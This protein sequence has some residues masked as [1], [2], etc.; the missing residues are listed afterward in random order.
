MEQVVESEYLTETK[1]AILERRKAKG[2]TPEQVFVKHSLHAVADV[3]HKL[4][5]HAALVYLAILGTS[6]TVTDDERRE[7]F[8]VRNS[9][10]NATQLGDRQFRRAV[11]LLIGAGYVEADTGPGRK[12]RVRLTAKGKRAIPGGLRLAS[13]EDTP[14]KQKR[15]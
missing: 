9:F 4:G 10:R 15:E 6:S 5:S 14:R 3:S 11:S 13:P 2:I 7:G 1:R 8:T 12:P